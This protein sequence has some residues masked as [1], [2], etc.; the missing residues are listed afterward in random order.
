MLLVPFI[1]DRA[2]LVALDQLRARGVESLET[3]PDSW[4]RTLVVP[5]LR[6]RGPGIE[7]PKIVVVVPESFAARGDGGTLALR[8][9]APKR[10]RD[11]G[12]SGDI[13]RVHSHEDGI[14]RHPRAR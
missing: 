11:L 8:M 4:E 14:S 13:R 5:R 6:L 10:A 9:F 7:G 2:V 12:R 3:I 1:R